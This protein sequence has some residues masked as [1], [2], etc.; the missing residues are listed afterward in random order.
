MSAHLLRY[1]FAAFFFIH[2]HVAYAALRPPTI[3]ASAYI[4]IDAATG[5]VLAEKNADQTLPPASL[6]K[7]MSDYVITDALHDGYIS[8]E[9]QVLISEKAWR[10]KGSKMFVLVDT[11]ITVD[12]LLKGMIIQSGNDA[13]IAL[14]EHVAGSEEAFVQRMN[15][16]AVEL[17]M[18][19]TVFQNATGWPD[20]EHH[21]TARDLALL[22]RAMIQD[23][24]EQYA[25]YAE[26]KFSWGGIEQTNR[27]RLLW[28]DPSVDGIKTGHTEE[29]GYCLVS[30]AIKNDMRLVSVV[31]GTDSDRAR[32]RESQKLLAFGFRNFETHE[33]YPANTALKQTRLWKGASEEI[34]VGVINPVV[35]SLARGEKDKLKIQISTEKIIEAPVKK[36]QVLG[37]LTI[38]LKDKTL[39]NQ[40][41]VALKEAEQGDLFTLLVDSVKLFLFKLLG[42]V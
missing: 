37:V 33:I 12:D 9:D 25:L 10:M 28:T 26:K 38:T 20:P 19:R 30:S 18:A 35:L 15:D 40:P 3:N 6:T 34:E 1:F 29:A 32:S 4:L 27:N 31:M 21:S 17:G 24:P 11:E 41:V 2:C 8:L 7:M 22:A 36:G 42:G 14:A 39:V 13:T 5:T 23:H 16:M